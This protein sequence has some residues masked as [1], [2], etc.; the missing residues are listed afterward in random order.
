[1]TTKIKV[2]NQ[3][4]AIWNKADIK[5]NIVQAL[6]KRAHRSNEHLKC[7]CLCNPSSAHELLFDV[8][9][10]NGIYYIAKNKARI[11]GHSEDCIYYEYRD[12]YEND[13]GHF[14]SSIFKEPKAYEKSERTKAGQERSEF[15]TFTKLCCV[16]LSTATLHAFHVQNKNNPTRDKLRNPTEEQFNKSLWYA[17]HKNTEIMA[18]GKSVF[19]A[20]PKGSWLYTG[21]IDEDIF[22]KDVNSDEVYT[23]NLC[24]KTRKGLQKRTPKITGR[25]LNI[26]RKHIVNMSHVTSPPY[27]Y[28]AVV[29]HD[30][31]VVRLFIYPVHLEAGTITFIESSKERRF[32]SLLLSKNNVFIKPIIGNEF[33]RLRRDLLLFNGKQAYLD[34]V[35][36]PD[37]I[38][39][40]HTNIWIIEV[41][42]YENEEYLRTMER[43]RE[44]FAVELAKPLYKNYRFYV[45]RMSTT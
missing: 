4:L 40:G 5:S 38:V 17:M 14:T 13:E 34:L 18:N 10:R 19:A 37:F 15:F 31:E 43:K 33:R 42:G 1:M 26:A 27:F 45:E 32:T 25:R 3:T 22:S 35:Y 8:R 29:N 30:N 7:T 23:I 2:G 24:Y 44:W 6:L 20:L 12:N 41:S 28:F 36:R 16:L 39:L 9:R 21:I 11:E